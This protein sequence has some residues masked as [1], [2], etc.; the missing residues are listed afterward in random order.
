MNAEPAVF[1]VDDDPAVLRG[2]SRLLRLVKFTVVTF[3]SAQEFLE[4]HDPSAPGCLVLDMTMPGLSGLELQEALTTKDSSIPIIFL[5]SNGD[6]PKKVQAMKQGAFDFLTKPVND[7]VLI[8]AVH[9]ALE[10]DRIERQA[11]ERTE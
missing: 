6:V 7:D 4:R 9:G 3:G 8:R 10:K 2:L 11:R 1:I 5:T